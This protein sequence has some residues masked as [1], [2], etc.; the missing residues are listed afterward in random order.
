LSVSP[1]R[2]CPWSWR[3]ILKLRNL[4]KQF[5]KFKI[6]DGSKVFLWFDSW[7]PDG[8]LLDVYGFRVVYDAGSNLEAKVSSIIRDG[9]WFWNGSRS[10]KLVAIQSRLPEVS[11]GGVLIWPFGSLRKGFIP[12]LRLGSSLGRKCQ[13][14][15]GGNQ[16]GFQK[17]FLVIL[18][19]YS[20]FFGM[21]FP[22]KRGCVLG[23]MVAV[24]SALFA[25]VVQRVETIFSSLTASAEEFG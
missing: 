20:L 15:L 6:G 3:K 22:P 5:L 8:C 17:P 1:P 11:I 24:Y 23:V 21:P 4:A 14:F 25:L 7:H 19:F 18:L 13:L 10:D 9:E 16:Y 2:P 12:A